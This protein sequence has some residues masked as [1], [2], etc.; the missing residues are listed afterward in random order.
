MRV[1]NNGDRRIT[2]LLG[3]IAAFKA[4]FGTG[5]DDFGHGRSNCC[6]AMRGLHILD[7]NAQAP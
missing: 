3:V 1:Q 2:V 7:E 6:G 4:A 5:E